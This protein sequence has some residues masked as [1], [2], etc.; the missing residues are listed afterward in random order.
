MNLA[1]W[2][3]TRFEK[4]IEWISYIVILLHSIFIYTLFSPI[5][6]LYEINW[7]YQIRYNSIVSSVIAILYIL[8]GIMASFIPSRIRKKLLILLAIGYLF[9]IY[10]AVLHDF[11]LFGETKFPR[12][13]ALA[14]SV[15]VYIL[16]IIL[17]PFFAV[18]S[19]PFV[20]TFLIGYYIGYRISTYLRRKRE[21]E[22]ESRKI[23]NEKWDKILGK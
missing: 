10:F 16:M 4:N 21:S 22:S 20:L 17:T 8:F 13:E 9:A 5:P 15:F 6:I 18:L 14:S 23:K 12:M 11:I 3:D 19:N 7:I 1:T 2:A